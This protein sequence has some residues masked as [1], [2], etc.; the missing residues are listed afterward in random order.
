MIRRVLFMGS[1]EL[2]L[3]V[4]RAIH[5]ASPGSIAGILTLDDSNDHRS[6]LPRFR[7]FAAT[8][9]MPLRIAA[10]RA[11]SEQIIQEFNPD[12]CVVVCWYW[13]LGEKLLVSIPYG[14]IGVHNS[15]LPRYRGGSPLVWQL[16][17][18][19]TEI[20]F[21]ILTLT[22][23]MDEG[24][25]WAS[26]RLA[27]EPEERI[28]QVLPRLEAAIVEELGS[29][30]PRI[31]S[32]TVQPA[33]QDAREATYCMARHPEDGELD[34]RDPAANV[35]N[36]IRA[37]SDPYPGAFS[38]WNGKLVRCWRA[39]LFD[40]PWCGAPGQVARIR[41]DGVVVIAGDHR[42]VVLTEIEMDGVRDA[43][44]RLI[45]S[46]RHRFTRD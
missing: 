21:S 7:E 39:T 37:Q 3:A 22:S 36:S 27:V 11:E 40:R 25:I 34:W 20:G 10:N 41:T 12:L 26:R 43:A 9:N 24:P 14:F 5:Q 44:D 38:Y 1:K 16:I 6:A 46:Y 8:V 23:G 31:L 29:L 30:Y 35:F 33:P 42:A 19:E 15:L 18:G 28:G 4:L 17:Q 2:G 13:M 45:T 32:G